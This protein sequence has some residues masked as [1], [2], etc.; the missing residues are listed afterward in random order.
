MKITKVVAAVLLGGTVGGAI[1]DEGK[2]NW[3]ESLSIATGSQGATYYIY[4]SG[5]GNL[6]GEATGSTF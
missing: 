2:E 3:P 1:A 5:W 6:V 4:G